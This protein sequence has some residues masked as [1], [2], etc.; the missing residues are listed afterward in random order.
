M[1]PSLSRLRRVVAGLALALMPLLGAG[2]D[3]AIL[4]QLQAEAA[5]QRESE[6]AA[7]QGQVERLRE[8]VAKH[9]DITGD[10]KMRGAPPSLDLNGLELSLA[11]LVDQYQVSESPTAGKPALLGAMAA[12]PDSRKLSTLL[13][14]HAAANARRR[15]DER[16]W[17][18]LLT[19]AADPDWAAQELRRRVA[20]NE[21][22]VVHGLTM[23][24]ASRFA[25]DLPKPLRTAVYRHL[26]AQWRRGPE[27][28]D[29]EQVWDLLFNLD[30]NRA[31]ADVLRF[32]PQDELSVVRL[33]NHYAGPS[34]QVAKAARIWIASGDPWIESLVGVE[35]RLLILAS[36]PQK[37]WS[38]VAAYARAR[39]NGFADAKHAEARSYESRQIGKVMLALLA[40]DA[41]A[42][43]W[44]LWRYAFNPG[45]ETEHQYALLAAMVRSGDHR[46]PL[47][48]ACWL[49]R[50]ENPNLRG[51]VESQMQR[52][53]GALAGTVLHLAS[54]ITAASN[55]MTELMDSP[56]AHHS[57]PQ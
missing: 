45:L 14:L 48:A 2:Q 42:A 54:T 3:T 47:A 30:R 7:W 25:A 21:H 6:P 15:D 16:L 40:I 34:A 9:R 57:T 19:E 27:S 53:W 8:A 31:R 41:N 44:Q 35:L 50:I 17:A 11:F 38:E 39:L 13:A 18:R 29:G 5:R 20:A 23:R 26:R 49:R 55:C 33:L 52:D 22:L 4:A 46:G 10:W 24:L 12:N 51:H 56:Q 36:D 43:A 32:F 1:F 28:G 37:G